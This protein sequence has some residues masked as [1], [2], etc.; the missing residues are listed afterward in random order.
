MSIIDISDLL[1]IWEVV[2]YR[3]LSCNKKWVSVIINIS[4][5]ENAYIVKTRNF[6]ARIII[7][8]NL[9]FYS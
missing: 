2:N 7:L 5:L 9:N 8:N 1:P 3:C 4:L 6:S